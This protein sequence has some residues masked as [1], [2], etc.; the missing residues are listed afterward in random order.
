MKPPQPGAQTKKDFLEAG[1]RIDVTTYI[2]PGND[3]PKQLGNRNDP[4]IG[5]VRIGA[6][7]RQQQAETYSITVGSTGFEIKAATTTRYKYA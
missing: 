6:T 7:N 3:V 1:L 2:L 4:S 5:F